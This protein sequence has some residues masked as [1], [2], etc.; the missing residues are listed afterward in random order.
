MVNNTKHIV[1]QR[2]QKQDLEIAFCINYDENYVGG[3]GG[4]YMNYNMWIHCRIY[5]YTCIY[6]CLIWY[7]LCDDDDDDDANGRHATAFTRW[8]EISTSRIQVNQ[9]YFIRFYILKLRYFLYHVILVINRNACKA[10]TDQ[11]YII[12]FISQ[13]SL[14][15]QS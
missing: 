2:R 3:G 5:K 9:F 12:V 15:V 6:S 10:S 8:K 13:Y 14:C 4:V 11:A 7:R 1:Q